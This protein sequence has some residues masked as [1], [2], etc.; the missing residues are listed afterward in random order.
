[1]AHKWVR[2]LNNPCRLGGPICF[3]AGE[4][5]SRGPQAGLVATEP[6]PSGGSPMLQSA[7]QNH[8]WPKSRTGAYITAAAL[9]VLSASDRGHNQPRPRIALDGYPLPSEGS[10]MLQSGGQT[11]QWPTSGWGGYITTTAWG[12]PQ[13]FKAVRKIG[14]GPQVGLVPT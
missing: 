1:M 4:R 13:R 14:N 9:E 8:H 3:R 5:I 2:W 12:G 6:L 7:G 11:Q 10:T